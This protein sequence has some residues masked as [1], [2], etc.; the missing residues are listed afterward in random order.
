MGSKILR[1]GN[2]TSFKAGENHRY[3]KGGTYDY[4]H[5]EARKKINVPVGKIVH[6]KNGNWKDNSLENLQIMS[7]SEHVT[8]HNNKKKGTIKPNSKIRK[9][10]VDVLKLKKQGFLRK[11]I[12]NKLNINFR[13]VKRCLTKQWRNQYE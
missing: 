2:K 6:H 10:I 5:R 9:V 13:M 11:E 4:W 1:H 7:Q 12:A 3:W 8:L